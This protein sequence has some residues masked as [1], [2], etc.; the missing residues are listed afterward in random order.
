[1]YKDRS[2]IQ[3]YL[4]H[5]G[6]LLK[7]KKAII[8]KIITIIIQAKKICP[9]LQI[10]WN[11]AV[12]LK[13][14]F[15]LWQRVVIAPSAHSGLFLSLIESLKLWCCQSGNYIPYVLPSCGLV[16]T[17]R[18]ASFNQAEEDRQHARDTAQQ[19]GGNC[20]LYNL[21]EYCITN[22]NTH[23]HTILGHLCLDFIMRKRKKIYLF[24]GCVLASL[25]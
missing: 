6:L 5:D 3:E 15:W 11:L 2:L 14:Y 23:T 19:C 13:R 24:R 22:T 9:Q 18:Q 16:H 1:M 8:V 17:W 20:D 4:C 10:F 12:D 7:K 25:I 21:L